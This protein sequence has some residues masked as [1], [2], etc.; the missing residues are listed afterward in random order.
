[1]VA[2]DGLRATGR[3]EVQIEVLNTWQ[4]QPVG[5]TIR[6]AGIVIPRLDRPAGRPGSRK[7]AG[8][9]YLLGGACGWRAP[10][11]AAVAGKQQ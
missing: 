10:A 6:P 5:P 7:D 1:M 3:R 4:A 11:R 9:L 2:A 8:E